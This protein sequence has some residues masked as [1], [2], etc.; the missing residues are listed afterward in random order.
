VTSSDGI[1]TS[2]VQISQCLDFDVNLL[3]NKSAM[4]N[5]LRN[6]KTVLKQEEKIDWTF[7]AI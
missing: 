5:N 4:L 2:S 7:L 6:F 3:L 1:V